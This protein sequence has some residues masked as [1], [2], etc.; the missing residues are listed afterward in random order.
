MEE[1]MALSSETKSINQIHKHNPDR[2][3]YYYGHRVPFGSKLPERLT[4][5]PII[6]DNGNPTTKNPEI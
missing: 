3:Y 5:T 2:G 1:K 4:V 6:E